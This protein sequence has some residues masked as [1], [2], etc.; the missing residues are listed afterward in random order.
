MAENHSNVKIF[1]SIA[2]YCDP[3]LIPTIEDALKQAKFP[4]NLRFG[5]VEQN[6]IEKRINI[7]DKPWKGQVRYLGISP[8]ESRGACWARAIAMS[9]YEDEKWFFQIDSHMRFDS[10]WDAIFIAAAQQCAERNSKFLI[11]SYPHSFKY[12]DGEPVVPEVTQAPIGHILNVDAKFK[13]DSL[14]LSFLGAYIAGSEEI[15]QGYHLGAGCIFAPGKIVYEI[16]YDPFLYFQGE[17]QTLAVRAFTHGWDIFHI[18]KLPIY[19]LYEWEGAPDRPRHWAEGEDVQRAQRW[20]DLDKRS[21]ER[22]THLLTEEGDIGVYGLGSKRTLDDYAIFS[23][24]DY[25]T[26]TIANRA[27]VGPWSEQVPSSPIHR[28]ASEQSKSFLKRHEGRVGVIAP[29]SGR[30]DYARMLALQLASQEQV[31]DYV[32]FHQ[33]GQTP[34]YQWAIEDLHLPYAYDWVQS[35]RQIAQ[36]QRYS[37]PLIKLIDLQCDYFVWADYDVIYYANHVAQSVDLINSH[38]VD[39]VLDRYCDVLLVDKDRNKFK[40]HIDFESAHAPGGASPSIVFNRDFALRLY[41]DLSENSKDE[42]LFYADAVLAKKTAPLFK[43]HKSE[44]KISVCIIGYD[45]SLSASHWIREM[46]DDVAN[47]VA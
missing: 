26:R 45:G 2:S 40:K 35:E 9:L 29:L 4:E 27:R 6:H 22:F 25:R 24:I 18:P 13:P 21:K 19:H 47:P 33:S 42:N 43:V 30:P 8:I 16:P 1:I 20:W 15:V 3:L 11:S 37:I 17:E 39:L 14:E 31:P 10:N 5:V 28:K 7:Q 36:D 12:E 38:S 41:K 34:N 32:I 44:N 23:G 46:Q